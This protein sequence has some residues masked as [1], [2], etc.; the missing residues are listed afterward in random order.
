[1]EP[2]EE[3]AQ[4]KNQ[5]ASP[6]DDESGP[7]ADF[8]SAKKPEA[9]K[10]G[11]AGQ[12]ALEHF[13]NAASLGYLPQLQSLAARLI[14]DPNAGVDANL[15]A[16]GFDIQQP[17]DTYLSDRDANLK[18]LQQQAKDYP[19]AS[20]AG[21]IAGALATAIPTTALA[22]IN[23]A[24]RMGRIV[25]AAKGGALLGALSNPGDKEGEVDISQLGDRAR[26]ALSGAGLAA[27][28]QGAIEGLSAAAKAFTNLPK[29]LQARAEER[30][31]KASG[32]MLRDYRK[33][34]GQDKIKELGRLMLD[35]GM[36][37]PGMS[38]SDIADAAAQLEEKR[39]SQLGKILEDLSNQ[40]AASGGPQVTRDQIADGIRKRL[41]GDAEIPSV[42]KNNKYFESLANDLQNK[43][44]KDLSISELQKLKEAVGKQINWKRLPDADIPME[45][46]FNRA[47]FG[48]LKGALEDRA[49]QLAKD[50][51]RS[52]YVLAKKGY[53]GAKTIG[54]IASDQTLRQN[55]NRFFSPSDYLTTATG[56]IAG[57]A[58]GDDLESKLKNA[59]I[60][61]SL[62]IANKA[63]RTY[64]TPLVSVGLDKAGTLLAKTPLSAAG[65]IASPLLDAAERGPL[66]STNALRMLSKPQ[67]ERA[68][69][70]SVAGG[71]PPKG[72]AK[73]AQDG[74]K[75][76]GLDDDTFQQALQSPKTKQLLIQASDLAP[77]SKALQRIKD[78]IQKG[79]K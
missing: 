75:K 63:M 41:I 40:E 49:A 24:S 51:G 12:A 78:Q 18:R 27:G 25:Q 45:E 7:W 59:A 2:W 52:D 28:G 19:Y 21:S 23:A 64:G 34:A 39:G 72:E 10:Q 42:I 37:K 70:R 53:E 66:A 32:A 17:K 67:L 58:T 61:A 54:K 73:W 77:G 60:G 5:V 8:Q 76:L 26:N 62:G 57:A 38:V 20:G 4:A 55:A 3:Y 6:S 56:A 31:F 71:E 29:S 68:A 30:A 13:G 22:P 43:G 46:Q 48:E 50:A 36:I 47:L 35:E 16:Q 11:T 74:A 14:P 69:V 33:A 1:M 79:R 65:E 44:A 9:P 15:R